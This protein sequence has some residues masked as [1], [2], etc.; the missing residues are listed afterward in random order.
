MATPTKP[1]TLATVPLRLHLLEE[2]LK[3]FQPPE[4]QDL[5]TV[6]ASLTR[7]YKIT[8]KGAVAFPEEPITWDM[9]DG[10][11]LYLGMDASL[12]TGWPRCR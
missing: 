1:T 8:Q 3:A 9:P 7:I 11:L 12:S 4:G 10:E 2:K 6:T 5:T